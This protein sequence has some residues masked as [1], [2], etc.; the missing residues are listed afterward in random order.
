MSALES[1]SQPIS[2]PAP[3]RG[4]TAGFL[5][6]ALLID[7]NSRPREGANSTRYTRMIPRTKFQFPPPRGGERRCAD[8][9]RPRL[10]FNSRPREG[11]NPHLVQLHPAVAISIPAPARGRTG[12]TKMVTS[13]IPH[14]NSRP[15]E[16][17]NGRHGEQRGHLLISIPAPARGRTLP[18]L[19]KCPLNHISI[20]APARGRTVG[21]DDTM[22]NA[23]FQ[24]PPPRGGEQS[25]S[26]IISMK[27]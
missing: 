24:F 21:T 17:A 4:R 2:I 6:C 15:R 23:Q 27:H 3:A 25:A 18:F 7:F 13:P 19:Q 20:P 22:T 14:F 10:Y 26:L 12:V 9:Q 11:A 1:L 16:G 5:L 8:S